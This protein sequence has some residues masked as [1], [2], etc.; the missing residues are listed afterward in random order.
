MIQ[1]VCGDKSVCTS[2]A[3]LVLACF[4][5]VCMFRSCFLMSVAHV[6]RREHS[7]RGLKVNVCDARAVLA[8]AGDKWVARTASTS[9]G[10]SVGTL[11]EA[12]VCTLPEAR[13]VPSLVLFGPVEGSVSDSPGEQC[14][15]PFA[16][17]FPPT[18]ETVQLPAK[19]D[20]E[21]GQSEMLDVIKPCDVK[22]A[23]DDGSPDA[24]NRFSVCGLVRKRGDAPLAPPAGGTKKA[25][26]SL[27]A[28]LEIARDDEAVAKAVQDFDDLT[29][30]IGTDKSKKSHW[31]TWQAVAEARGNT[32]LPMTSSSIREVSGILRASGYR[33]GYAYALEAKQQHM[34]AGY[35]WTDQLDVS[36]Q[37][38]KRALQRGLGPSSK[39]EEVK[40][41][42]W[43]TL[44][45]VRAD[46]S[47]Q[48]PCWP[49]GGP[50]AW[51]FG[52]M[53]VL[54][55]VELSTLTMG[56]ESIQVDPTERRI[57]L[58][59][60]V[61]K[62]DPKARGC[63]RT[64]DCT[65]RG[66]FTLACA[67]CLGISLISVQ[68]KRLNMNITDPRCWEAPLIGTVADPWMFA[69]K[70]AVI[71]AAQW[72]VREL[73]RLSPD[74]ELKL[75][76]DGVTGHFMRRSGVKRLA[77]SGVPVEIIQFMSRHSSQAVFGY[78]EGAMEECPQRHEMLA[79]YLANKSE[80]DMMREQFSA[81]DKRVAKVEA[82][83]SQA[84]GDH[85]VQ[86]FAQNG[87]EPQMLKAEIQKILRPPAVLHQ[88][89]GKVHSTRGCV[90]RGSPA[91]W[92]T[93]C[94]WPWVVASC[95]TVELDQEQLESKDWSFCEKCLWD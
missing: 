41:E 42:W 66:T 78:I 59:L 11:P 94:G 49:L 17:H 10:P 5:V 40:L 43:E 32:A 63:R 57:T 33:S 85:A 27:T 44:W 64:L 21:S 77:R 13:P 8:K 89:T 46:R 38:A 30:A 90:F 51:A 65:C 45:K 12:S 82:S 87:V 37:D 70:E 79:K 58:G 39:S 84:A 53:F 16:M 61:S 54:R 76:P 60:S 1:P 67:Y 29:Y 22:S 24:T 75:D 48:R 35:A 80:L 15:L 23:G 74:L 93:A 9:T 26:G 7:S 19:D 25:R 73:L 86:V 95:P 72:D 4:L 55:E 52:T 71:E 34:R 62:A 83:S 36:L 14:V 88:S 92:T 28:A 31:N 18:G 2:L 81:L 91:S 56:P 50:T 6:K 69:E 68:E 3:S 20:G 47:S